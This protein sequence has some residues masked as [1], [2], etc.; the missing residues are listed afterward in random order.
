[1]NSMRKILCI[2]F[3]FS[4]YCIVVIINSQS[5][6]KAEQTVTKSSIALSTTT[7][8]VSGL[9]ERKNA[10]KN[11]KFSKDIYLT[12]SELEN[13]TYDLKKILVKPIIK[14]GGTFCQNDVPFLLNVENYDDNVEIVWYKNNTPVGIGQYYEAQKGGQYFAKAKYK[15]NWSEKSD[16]VTIKTLP[17]LK[18][19]AGR[20]QNLCGSRTMVYGTTNIGQGVWSTTSKTA[21]IDPFTGKVTN[22][23]GGKCHVF[24]W[25]VSDGKCTASDEVEVC[26]KA[27]PSEA[28]AGIDQHIYTTSTILLAT[29]PK[30]GEG[31][32]SFIG[33]TDYPNPF[34]LF[35]KD[36]QK[37]VVSGLKQGNSYEFRWK[38]ANDM[39]AV[40]DTVV[41][42]VHDKTE[43][44]EISHEQLPNKSPNAASYF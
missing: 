10:A 25:T 14:G 26:V 13:N 34:V 24:I 44:D 3:L 17:K 19:N 42:Y 15:G 38:V 29:F 6:S 9:T 40:S 30:T 35:D 22:M 37:S 32:W 11:S 31:H 8:E 21:K 4:L 28:S 16:K 2:C 5:T 41:I 36:N 39:C 23:E 43:F 18:P 12:E 7:N 1:M 20:D 27:F 33:G